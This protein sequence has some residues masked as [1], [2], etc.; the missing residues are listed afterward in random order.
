MTVRRFKKKHLYIIVSAIIVA[1]G[2]LAFVLSYGL[3]KGWDA[4][5]KWFISDSAILLYMIVGLYLVIVGVL[6]IGDK[7]K[8]L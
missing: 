1:I 6:L 7:V 5:G 3:S 2:L 8:K 4:L